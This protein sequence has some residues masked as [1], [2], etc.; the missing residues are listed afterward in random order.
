MNKAEED[1]VRAAITRRQTVTKDQ[2]DSFSAHDVMTKKRVKEFD[3]DIVYKGEVVTKLNLALVKMKGLT[4]ARVDT[5]KELYI[6]KLNIFDNMKNT[7][8][9]YLLKILADIVTQIEFS[10]QEAWGFE[11]DINMH[12]FW[13]LPNCTCPKIDN[14]ERYSCNVGY[15][16]NADCLIHGLEK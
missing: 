14:E 1:W 13:T 12:R 10:L 4:Q 7:T 15:Y 16:T 3:L 5:I 6:E 9:P 8:K 11:P 2:A